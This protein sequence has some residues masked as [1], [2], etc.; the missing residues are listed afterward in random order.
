M[1]DDNGDD[2]ALEGAVGGWRW[3]EGHHSPGSMQMAPA[4]DG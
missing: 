1:S 2:L 4:A 3:A